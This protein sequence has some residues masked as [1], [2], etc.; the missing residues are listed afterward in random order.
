MG[1]GAYGCTCPAC[2]PA[3]PAPRETGAVKAEPK[4]YG[5]RAE[6]RAWER[7]ARRHAKLHEKRA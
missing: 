3:G 5:N 7:E 4:Q 2:S 1:G 6:R